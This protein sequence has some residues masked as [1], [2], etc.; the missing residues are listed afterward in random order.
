MK[1]EN[2]KSFDPGEFLTEWMKASADLWQPA[3]GMWPSLFGGAA[4]EAAE[5]AGK[6]ASVSIDEAWKPFAEFWQSFFSIVNQEGPE[7]KGRP[8]SAHP[9][10]MIQAMQPLL[11]GYML[12][13]KQWMDGL[14][15]GGEPEN[16]DEGFMNMAR[17]MS[18]AFYDSYEKEFRQMLNLPQL[19][20]A[21]F[22][23]ERAN[24]MVE[25]FSEFH[26]TLSDFVQLLFE[27]MEKTLH[28][29]RDEVSRMNDEG[30]DV[31]QDSKK[32]YQVWMRKLEENY[33]TL[34]RSPEYCDAMGNILKALHDYKTTK[35]ALLIDVLQDL[36]VP[37]NREMDDVYK[38]L[39][40]LKK[41]VRELENRGKGHE[42]QKKPKP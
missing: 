29:M 30:Q 6:D 40:V 24:R 32:V 34:L 2:K 15:A 35:Q 21:R 11:A 17:N 19:G 7:K 5:K 12:F 9:E 8:V 23:Q 3:A 25:K 4:K 18:K 16:E 26:S 36:P 31:I 37:T 13:Q 22:Y 1:D 41:K 10:F 39:Y 33:L 20:M 42:G 14:Q 38:E 28:S 27:P